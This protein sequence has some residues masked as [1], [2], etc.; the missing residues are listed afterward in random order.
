MLV[1]H[2]SP[3]NKSCT[4]RIEFL[5]EVIAYISATLYRN[6]F[7]G[8]S[9]TFRNSKCAINLAARVSTVGCHDMTK[10]ARV[11]FSGLSFLPSGV[12]NCTDTQTSAGS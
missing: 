11:D 12:H 1:Y 7:L 5:T 9:F 10:V 4:G 6:D 8:T 3:N 2:L